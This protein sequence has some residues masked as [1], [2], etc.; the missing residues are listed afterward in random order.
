MIHPQAEE[1]RG[2]RGGKQLV[3][4]LSV[5]PHQFAT[6]YLFHMHPPVC[7]LGCHGFLSAKI[8]R[9]LVAKHNI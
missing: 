4:V 9:L 8:Y 7:R 1:C 2:G 6:S 3:G 5:I